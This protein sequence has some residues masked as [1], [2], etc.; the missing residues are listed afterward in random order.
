MVL[1]NAMMWTFS[2]PIDY[3]IAGENGESWANKYQE[4]PMTTKKKKK[5]NHNNKKE[6]KIY[7][8]ICIY[9]RS[10]SSLL[11]LLFPGGVHIVRPTASAIFILVN[12]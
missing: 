10:R 1:K 5:K 6:E 9:R 12:A 3:V 2:V 8:Y 11:Q 4:S 7:I